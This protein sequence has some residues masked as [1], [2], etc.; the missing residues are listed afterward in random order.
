[1]LQPII[2]TLAEKKLVGKRLTM[3]AAAD[4]TP[5]L[6]R[7]FMPRRKEITQAL[8]TDLFNVKIF[9]PGYFAQF[10]PNALFEKWAAVEVTN[11]DGM[12]E[13]MEDF[14]LPGGLYAVFRYR[15]SSAD[16]RIFQFI[17]G[18]WLPSSKDYELDDRPHFDLLGE[19]YRNNDLDS[20]EQIWVPIKRTGREEDWTQ[21]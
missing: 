18:E 9:Q 3:S 14:T 21:I 19:K 6:W 15:G 1:M 11:F 7:S 4:R 20:E 17:F 5:E 13:D 2:T 12:P 10:S 16:P 8:G